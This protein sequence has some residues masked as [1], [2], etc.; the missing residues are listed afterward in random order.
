V[1]VRTTVVR[2]C[3]AARALTLPFRLLPILAIA[4]NERQLARQSSQPASNG[5]PADQ[6]SNADEDNVVLFLFSLHDVM[7]LS[8]LKVLGYR[9]PNL[10][11]NIFSK[12]LISWLYRHTL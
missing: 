6:E 2:S 12:A 1:P 10:Y 11:K 7:F 8:L 9:S 4:Q 5:R 3:S